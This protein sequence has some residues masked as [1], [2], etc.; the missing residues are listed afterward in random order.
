MSFFKKQTSSISHDIVSQPPSL[1]VPSLM[2][3]LHLVPF[4]SFHL[5]K[6]C[7]IIGPPGSAQE[8]RWQTE[9]FPLCMAQ[10]S[11][12]GERKK[13]DKKRK[14]KKKKK[15]IGAEGKSEHCL[16]PEKNVIEF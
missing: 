2:L 13:N 9:F 14:E 15:E 11:L 6:L 16:V 8:R 1:A 7:F 10:A 12:T 3:K 5:L 4:L